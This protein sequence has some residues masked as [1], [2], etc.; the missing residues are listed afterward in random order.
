MSTINKESNF[1]QNLN[2]QL[3]RKD[4][5]LNLSYERMGDA[6]I[7][8]ICQAKD[9]SHVKQLDLSWNEISDIGLDKLAAC[10]SLI[11]LTHLILNS[12][13][14][15]DTGVV[16]L[17]DTEFLSKLLFL[18]PFFKV[19]EVELQSFILNKYFR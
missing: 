16:T 15:G 5:V 14:I 18:N 9:L 7:A 1:I 13:K 10:K 12:N 3:V 19:V 4:P 8:F 17:S 6:G 2:N 11:S